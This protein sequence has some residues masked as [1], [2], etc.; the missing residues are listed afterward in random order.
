MLTYDKATCL[1]LLVKF[2][3]PDRLINSLQG[4]DILLFFRTH[5]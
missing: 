1:R 5:I 2:I 3:L 4:S